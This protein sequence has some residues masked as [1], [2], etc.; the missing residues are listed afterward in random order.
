MATGRPAFEGRSQA[1][2]IAAILEHEPQPMTASQPMAPPALERLVRTCLAKDPDER[3]QTAHDVKLQL[4]WIAEAGSQ[5]G[6]PAPLVARRKSRER[7]GW[8][9]AVALLVPLIVALA[10]SIIHLRE[11]PPKAR[12]IRFLVPAPERSR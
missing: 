12:P 8:I 1:S 4:Q 7:L 11:S 3:V 10:P 6:I 9:F 2:L 5:A